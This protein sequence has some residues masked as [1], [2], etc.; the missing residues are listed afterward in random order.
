[1]NTIIQKWTH[2]IEE[3]LKSSLISD[4]LKSDI[5]IFT[6]AALESLFLDMKYSY[7]NSIE[8]NDFF[9]NIFNDKRINFY[10]LNDH[11]TI[12]NKNNIAL[13]IEDNSNNEETLKKTFILLNL[14]NMLSN[15]NLLEIFSDIENFLLK[16]DSNN[17]N[18]LKSKKRI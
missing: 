14:N 16:N 11:I 7:F 2:L 13:Y 15:Q 6:K 8:D 18:I 5:I 17:H 12:K 9:H 10:Y 1:M 4:N 3:K